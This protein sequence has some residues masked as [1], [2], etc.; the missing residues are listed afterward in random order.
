MKPIDP[1][2]TPWDFS[3]WGCYCDHCEKFFDLPSEGRV[4][5]YEGNTCSYEHRVCGQPARFIGYDHNAVKPS[6]HKS[7]CASIPRSAD[8][9]GSDPYPCDCE[10][11]DD[12]AREV[13][14]IFY[15]NGTTKDQD[16][17]F[18]KQLEAVAW[19]LSDR[20]K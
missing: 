8:S 2:P 6:E 12:L 18:D 10:I 9:P 11:V 19:L 16:A 3:T 1:S 5:T 7:W 14:D 20:R 17:T 15:P 13:M 4:L